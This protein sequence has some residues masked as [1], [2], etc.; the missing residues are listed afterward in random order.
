MIAQF[1]SRAYTPPAAI[2]IPFSFGDDYLPESGLKRLYLSAAAPWVKTHQSNKETISPHLSTRLVDC[3]DTKLLFPIG[4]KKEIENIFPFLKT[5][6]HDTNEVLPWREKGLFLATH[7]TLTYSP[8]QKEDATRLSP[9]FHFD[10][11]SDTHQRA[12][13]HLSIKNDKTKKA[14]WQ[15]RFNAADWIVKPFTAPFPNAIDFF[16]EGGFPILFQFPKN[17]PAGFPICQFGTENYTPLFLGTHGF[18][19][20]I[21][22]WKVNFKVSPLIQLS[23]PNGAFVF[24]MAKENSSKLPWGITQKQDPEKWLPWLKYSR[25]LNPGWGI[26]NPNDPEIDPNDT[27]II[28]LKKV[29]LMLNEVLFTR[30]DDHRLIAATALQIRFDVDSYLPSF[31]ASLPE[32]AREAVMPDPNPVLV[33]AFL[34][35][36]E[37]LFYVEKI[38]RSRRFG[39][40]GVDI[41]GRGMACELDTPYA[42][43][44]HHLNT[45]AM[46]AR[47][48]IDAS[49][50]YTGYDVDWQL[51]DWLIPANT[52]SFQGS[53][54]GVAEQVSNAAGAVL[55][56]HWSAKT[57]RL[58]PRTPFLPWDTDVVPHIILPSAVAETESIEWIEAPDYNVVY[59]SG[60]E[61]GIIAQIKKAGSAGDKPA[62]FETHALITHADCARQK[63]RSL[64]A[65]TCKKR[66]LTLSMPVLPESGIIDICKVIQLTDTHSATTGIV[67][68]NQISADFPTLR[69]SIQIEV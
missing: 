45:S 20:P 4:T 68:S 15:G 47:Q 65:N 58:L 53:A 54:I 52:F 39:Q 3:D 40:T 41:S 12:P 51:D 35:G 14:P 62:P 67:R 48:L 21:K 24:S 63:G 19:N 5:H 28:P 7:H 33:R 42:P 37:F 25:P 18:F 69:Q 50:E 27:I 8:S 1:P 9:F 26:T 6:W 16:V 43:T 2:A 49:L 59:V 29:Y 10:K 34:N 22:P 30:A 13:W 44:K 66:L 55:S 11:P 36:T 32:S 38:T 57:L 46:T 31:S 60:I 64:L 56:A 61:K 17:N 23:N